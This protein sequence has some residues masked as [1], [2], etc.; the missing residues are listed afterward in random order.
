MKATK[1]ILGAAL[2][3]ALLIGAMAG[4]AETPADPTSSVSPSPTVS[5]TPSESPAAQFGDFDLENPDV[6]QVLLGFPGT[7]TVMTVDGVD[8]SAEEYL[9]LL[10]RVTQYVGVMN[11]G[12]TSAIDWDMDT[13]NG[14]VS[15]YITQNAINQELLYQTIRKQCADRNITIT[16][17]EEIKLE[18]EIADIIESMGGQEEFE[19]SLKANNC[20]EDN[21]RGIYETFDF[22]YVSLQN[23]LFPAQDASALTA[24]ELAQWAADNGKMQV[25]HILFKTVDD[26]GNPLSDEEKEAARQKAEDT[27]AQLQ[28]SDDMENLFD[29][30]MNELSEDGRYSDGT[31]GAPDGYFFGEGEMVQE[32]EDAAKALGEH[33]LSG[34]VET[35]Y[36]YHILLRLP[37]DTEMAREAWASQ[38]DAT[39]STQMNDQMTAW[40][41]EAVIETNDTFS[42]I[43]PKDYYERLS[44]YREQL[45]AANSTTETE[46]DGAATAEPSATPAAEG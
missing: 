39:I 28:A 24:E 8:V 7:T 30:L 37:V 10:D 29:Q 14:T 27:L 1:K 2:S 6:T 5:A 40:M 11:F 46:T 35:S 31:L 43:D 45:A 13:G 34:I 4:C 3:G 21:L 26:S 38:Q 16:A 17:D 23:Q 25:K 36:G 22:L 18:Q 20:S 44:A 15:E 32:F 19:L 41:D 33:E 42:S 9:Y 12:A